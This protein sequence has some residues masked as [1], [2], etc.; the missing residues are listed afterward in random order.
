MYGH[1]QR[2]RSLDN[3]F[4]EINYLVRRYGIKEVNV[5]DSTFTTNRQHVIGFCQR[6]RREKINLLWTC[7][8]RVD[9]L[10]DEMLAEMKETLHSEDVKPRRALL[11]K[12]VAWVE[13]GKETGTIAYTF[14]LRAAGQCT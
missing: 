5:D 6:L 13:L 10:D 1:K 9:N 7:S 4:A 12:L 2:F 3:V 8:G 11:S 14:P